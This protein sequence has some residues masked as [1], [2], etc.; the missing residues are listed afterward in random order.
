MKNRS[1]WSDDQDYDLI[2]KQI[3]EGKYT[4]FQV[5]F[6]YLY[7][8]FQDIKCLKEDLSEHKDMHNLNMKETPMKTE[9]QLKQTVL[10]KLLDEVLSLNAKAGELGEGKCLNMQLL[11]KEYIKLSE[12]EGE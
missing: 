4:G 10:N 7:N 11:A 8:L 1:L 9:T 3:N 12:K 6:I 2:M 5:G